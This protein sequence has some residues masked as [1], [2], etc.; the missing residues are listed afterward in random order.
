VRR[1]STDNVYTDEKTNSQTVNM[2]YSSIHFLI[3]LPILGILILL[4]VIG[5]T[6][7]WIRLVNIAMK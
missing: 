4:V 3:A 7:Y 1:R 2:E 6:F 5:T